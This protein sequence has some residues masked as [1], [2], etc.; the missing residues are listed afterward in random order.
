MILTKEEIQRRLNSKDNLSNQISV[1]SETPARPDQLKNEIQYKDGKSHQGNSGKRLTEEERIT[2]GVLAQTAGTEIAGELMGVSPVTAKNLESGWRSD[3]PNTKSKDMELM[4]K[5]NDRLDETKLTIQE[6]AAD[7]LLNALGVITDD[8]LENA[9]LRDAADV[10]AKM[11]QVYKN[12][13]PS[14]ERGDSR[15]RVVIHQPKATQESS[16]DILEIGFEK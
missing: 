9:K 3:T 10:A 2:I 11:S 6:R 12:M 8:K 5:I 13:A 16:L 1:I 4:S 14:Q 7:R 15:V